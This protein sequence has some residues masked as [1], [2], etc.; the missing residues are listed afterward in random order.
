MRLLIKQKILAVRDSYYVYDE[1]GEIRYEVRDALFRLGH[2]IHVYDRRSGREVGSIHER[3]LTLLPEFE[4]VVNGSSRGNVRKQLTLF[5]PKYEVE[6][7]GW[8]VEG[9]FMGW[10]Y[11]VMQGQ[12]QV[13][14]IS[15]ELLNWSDTYCLEYQN[16]ADELPGLLLVIA[17][18]AVNCSKNR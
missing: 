8:S 15:K 4:I 5:R 9:D 7:L 3:F 1:S 12:R 13:M 17:I 18:D 6:Y 10:D 2:Q 14:T 16:P 11:R